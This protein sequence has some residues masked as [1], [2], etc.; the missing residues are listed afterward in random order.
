[1]WGRQLPYKLTKNSRR[2]QLEAEPQSPVVV[3][4]AQ[5]VTSLRISFYL[6]SY[7]AENASFPKTKGNNTRSV[8]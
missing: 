2:E 8:L 6:I 7:F 5:G 3:P 1:V 4:S